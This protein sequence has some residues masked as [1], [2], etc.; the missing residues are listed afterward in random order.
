MDKDNLKWVE[1]SRK[2]PCIVNQF[3]GNVHSKTPC[4]RKIKLVLRD[5]ND[6]LMHREGLKG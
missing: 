3:H 6:A 2:L 1:K 4:C 5:V